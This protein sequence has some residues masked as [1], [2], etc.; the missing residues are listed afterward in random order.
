MSRLFC[1]PQL[2]IAALVLGLLPAEDGRI[3]GQSIGYRGDGSGVFDARPPTQWSE[4][5]GVAWKAPLPYWGNG[6]PMAVGDRAFVMCEPGYGDLEAPTLLCFDLGTGEELWRQPVDPFDLLG[7]S[8]KKYKE[9]RREFWELDRQ[10]MQFAFAVWGPEKRAEARAEAAAAGIDLPK[11]IK[12]NQP[13]RNLQP[14]DLKDRRQEVYKELSKATKF[15]HAGWRYWGLHLGQTFATPV[16]DGEHIYIVTGYNNAACFTL[17]GE[18]RWHV[19]FNDQVKNYGTKEAFHSPTIH[20][21]KLV[22]TLAGHLRALDLRN[23]REIYSLPCKPVYACGAIQPWRLGDT[24]CLFVPDGTLIRAADGLV[25]AKGIGCAYSGSTPVIEGDVVVMVNSVSGGKYWG[26]SRADAPEGLTAYRVAVDGNKAKVELLWNVAGQGAAG[27]P[28]GHGGRVYLIDKRDGLLVFDV[29]SGKQV[30]K[31]GGRFV[32]HHGL[33]MAGDLLYTLGEDGSCDVFQVG[34]APRHLG[35][36][37]LQ[38][39]PLEQQRDKRIARLSVRVL[40]DHKGRVDWDFTQ[41]IPFAV[42][43]RLLIRSYDHLYCVGR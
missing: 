19:G 6:S 31:V 15:Y 28:V 25:L 40:P 38:V 33:I 24:D 2:L 36:N 8:A 5:K 9:L 16:S 26:D 14:K 30:A 32:A 42:G 29:G 35:T 43:N 22:F 39:D 3:A 12:G 13:L 7:G 23:G 10:T 11:D 37:N 21:G 20:D 1:V 17:D 4:D 41:S 34:G 27:T 18:P